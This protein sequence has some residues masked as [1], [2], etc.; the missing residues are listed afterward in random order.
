M[1]PSVCLPAV[2]R[3]LPLIEAMTKAKGAG[4]DTVEIWNRDINGLAD[5]RAW[6]KENGLNM[7]AMCTSDFTLNDASKRGTYLHGLAES[8]EAA[9]SLGCP[10]LIT[11]VGQE[12]PDVSREIQKRAIVEGLMEASNLLQGHAVTLAIEPLNIKV[13]HP[14]YFL[15]QAQEGAEIVREVNNPQ[16]KLLYDIYHQQVTE[17]NILSSMKANLDLIAHVHIAGVPGRHEPHLSCELDYRVILKALKDWGY[18][19]H[20]GLEY[21]PLQDPFTGLQAMAR[22]FSEL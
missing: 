6:L 1:K 7:S 16:I 3:G 17:G 4:F 11:Q 9:E 18:Q 15:T 19:G 2:F 12:L 21:M 5:L 14:G 22:L 10:V 8:I 20:I 13:D